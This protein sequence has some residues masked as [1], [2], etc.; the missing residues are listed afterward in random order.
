MA[1]FTTKDGTR[2]FYK[3]W[4]KGQPIVFSMGGLSLPMRRRAKC[5]SSSTR[6]I[7]SLWVG[8]RR[9]R[10]QVVFLSAALRR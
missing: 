6:A 8:F 2:I 10:R 7:A 3:D 9:D 1:Y 4:D 5:C